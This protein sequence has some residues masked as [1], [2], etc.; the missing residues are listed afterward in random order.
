MAHLGPHSTVGLRERRR[1]CRAE[2]LALLR[3][4]K[5]CLRLLGFTSYWQI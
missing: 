1:E 2:V 5:G 4:G 3:S